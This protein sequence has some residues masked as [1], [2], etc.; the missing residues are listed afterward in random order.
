MA[1]TREAWSA[2]LNPEMV[3]SKLISAGLFLVAHEMLL[4]SILRHPRFFFS[5]TLTAADGFLPSPK[6]AA[7]VLAL[8]PKGKNDPLR[9]SI[10]WWRTME[11][12]DA[13]DEIAIRLVTDARNKLAHEM[14]DIIG[15]AKPPEFAEH[16]GTLMGLVNKIEKWWI[17]NF[18]IATDPDWD[19]DQIDE[20]GV[21]P[22]SA[23]MMDMLTQVALGEGD[24][25]WEL[26]RQF[27]E[28]WASNTANHKQSLK[29]PPAT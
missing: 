27:E 14:T 11:A 4:D 5:D 2:L 7:S 24:Q 6:Y 28:F 26:H 29:P 10:A 18:E 17:I 9:G 20:A 13:A 23:W 19:G 21:V 22:G 15:G 8:D 25:A 1:D 12:I 3:R 16:F